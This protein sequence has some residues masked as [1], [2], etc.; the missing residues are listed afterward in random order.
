MA[1]E[2]RELDYLWH[3]AYFIQAGVR[4]S[5]LLLFPYSLD[6]LL[7]VSSNGSIGS[8][9]VAPRLYAQQLEQFLAHSRH[10]NVSSLDWKLD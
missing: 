5:L 9:R 10:L 8:M 6:D 7:S 2:Q 3:V 4:A 1:R